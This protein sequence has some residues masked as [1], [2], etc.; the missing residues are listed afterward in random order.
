MRLAVFVPLAGGFVWFGL[1]EL[2]RGRTTL[3]AVS[4]VIAC[5][6][7]V[8]LAYTVGTLARAQQSSDRAPT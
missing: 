8:V 6:F 5:L 3:A 2:S 1:T 7:V 4:L